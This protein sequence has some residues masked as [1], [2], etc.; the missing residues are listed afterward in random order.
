VRRTLAA[1][2]GAAAVLSVRRLRRTGSAVPVD[3]LLEGLEAPVEI[4]RDRYGIPHVFADSLADAARAQGWIH[5][6]DRLLQ[7][8]LSRRFAFGRLSELFGPRTLEL[9]RT[10][11]R[12]RLRS[13]AEGDEAAADAETTAILAAYCEGVNA[14]LLRARLPVELRL[15]RCRP[16][17]W[18]PLDVHAAGAVLTYTLSGNWEGELVRMRLAARLGEER[19]RRLDP[20]YPDHLPVIV[21]AALAATAERRAA[22]LRRVVGTGASN[23]WAIAGERTASGAPILANDPH[24]VLGMPVLWHVQHLSWDGGAAVGATLPGVP[25]IILGRN[26]DVAWG[27]TTAMLD[28]QDLYVERL[29]PDEPT[30]YEVDGGWET[31]QHARE[32][33]RVRGRR[34]PVVEEVLTTRHGPIVA[35]APSGEALALRWSAY[36]PGESA[37][38]LLDVLRAHSVEEVD[39]A[40]DR[41][42][43]PPHNFVFADRHGAIA[44]RLA[45]GPIPLRASD[46]GLVPVPGWAS[47]HE[48]DGYIPEAELPRARDPERGFLVTANN[49]VAGEGYPHALAAEFL[50][51]YRAERIETRLAE[52]DAATVDDCR[53]LQLDLLSL[54]GLELARIAQ[55]FPANGPLEQAALEALAAWD[56]ELTAESAGGAVYGVLVRFLFVHAYAGALPHVLEPFGE[57]AVSG[58]SVSGL[59]ERSRPLLLDQIGRASC[60]ERV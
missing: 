11:R 17:R 32:E 47:D 18:T 60:R 6:H 7:M 25:G 15:L 45:G 5:A 48:W 12:L 31:V 42:R 50:N 41:F 53:R 33:I 54:P 49:R 40:L 46:E 28:T 13:I 58:P 56:G 27:M 3:P 51:G 2:A 1:A 57:G 16:D 39:T 26:E 22:W 20:A 10:V 44:Y 30:R 36:E 21:P 34:Q 8:E 55:G 59:Y 52:L 23:N 35:R 43:A 4:L 38:A 37:R 9:D 24:L 14:A 29:D 19:A